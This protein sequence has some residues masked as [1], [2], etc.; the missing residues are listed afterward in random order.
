M[1]MIDVLKGSVSHRQPVLAGYESLKFSSRFLNSV[2]RRCII[3]EWRDDAPVLRSRRDAFSPW[4]NL[5]VVRLPFRGASWLMDG[6]RVSFVS[7]GLWFD[8]EL[9]VIGLLPLGD[10]R[11]LTLL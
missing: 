9:A 4:A 5:C 3:T 10:P 2:G 6:R 7:V 8:L 1:V 11:N